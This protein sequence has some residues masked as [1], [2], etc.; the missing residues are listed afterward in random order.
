MLRPLPTLLLLVAFTLPG[1]LPP[2]VSGARAGDAEAKA[3]AKAANC[4]PNKVTVEQSIPRANGSVVY[5]ITC[6]PNGPIKDMVVRVLC[7]GNQCTLL[8]GGGMAAPKQ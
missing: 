4:N 1:F 2:F 7:R 6:L 8:A 3:T 5:Q